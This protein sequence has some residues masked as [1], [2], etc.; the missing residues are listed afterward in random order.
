[1]SELDEGVVLLRQ[2]E[3]QHS[4]VLFANLRFALLQHPLANEAHLVKRRKLCVKFVREF[5]GQG[6]VRGT[7]CYYDLC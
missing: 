7:P 4:V 3:R 6:A 1:M 2:F 5:G